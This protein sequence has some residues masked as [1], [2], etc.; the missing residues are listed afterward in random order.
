MVSSRKLPI[1]RV[2]PQTVWCFQSSIYICSILQDT[3]AI[4]KQRRTPSTRYNLNSEVVACWLDNETTTRMQ[5]RTRNR[6]RVGVNSHTVRSWLYACSCWGNFPPG[7][8]RASNSV[9]QPLVWTVLQRGCIRSN[10]LEKNR[11]SSGYIPELRST[12]SW[13]A[14]HMVRKHGKEWTL[15]VC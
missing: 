11:M 12:F 7:T 9:N 8:I 3:V 6:R 5:V 13:H 10:H 14:R 2:W 1:F 15:L 4:Y